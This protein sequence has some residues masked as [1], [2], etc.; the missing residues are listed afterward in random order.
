M[1]AMSRIPRLSELPV[2]LRAG[3]WICAVRLGLWLVPLQKLRGAVAFLTRENR[4]NRGACSLPQFVWAVSAASRLVPR[5]TCLTKAVALHILL[6]RA[7]L[8]SSIHFG[9]AKEGERFEAHAWV[10]SQNRVVI[11]E[12]ESNR[13]VPMMVWE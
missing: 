13:Y 6:R 8:Q 9:V 10:E 7:G 3:L 4:R 5:A 12:F 2:L 11:G 1:A